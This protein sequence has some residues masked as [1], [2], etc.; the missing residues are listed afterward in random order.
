MFEKIRDML[1][2]LLDLDV[3]TITAESDIMDDLGA[4]SLDLV[5]FITELES[6]FG[7]MIPQDSMEGVRTV[8]QVASLIEA[9]LG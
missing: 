2:S 5:E 1:A 6:E 3:A 4:D 8:G 9:R 7:I